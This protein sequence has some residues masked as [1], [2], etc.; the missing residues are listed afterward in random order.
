[1]KASVAAEEIHPL[2]RAGEQSLANYQ[3]LKMIK[4]DEN[5]RLLP[6]FK[7]LDGGR[8]PTD[9]MQSLLACSA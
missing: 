9:L 3:S 5:V 2:K 7:Y 8:N 6:V 1:M 4:S